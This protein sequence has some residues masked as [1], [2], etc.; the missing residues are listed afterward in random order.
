M[1][2]KAGDDV[3]PLMFGKICARVF[4]EEAF[5]RLIMGEVEATFSSYKKLA[6]Y[7]SHGVVDRHL[8]TMAGSYFRSS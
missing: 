5:D 1:I 8:G 4:F 2:V 7:G 3:S 6:S